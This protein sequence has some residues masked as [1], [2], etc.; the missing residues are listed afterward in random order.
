METSVLT[1]ALAVAAA[2]IFSPPAAAA[3][4]SKGSTGKEQHFKEES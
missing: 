2:F 3:K 4:T 1:I